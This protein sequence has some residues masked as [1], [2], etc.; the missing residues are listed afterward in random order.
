MSSEEA[1]KLGA[2]IGRLTHP[3]P[4][5]DTSSRVSAKRSSDKPVGQF[6]AGFAAAHKPIPQRVL[7]EE[8]VAKLSS[9]QQRLI[10]GQLGYAAPGQR[11]RRAMLP[12][13][14]NSFQINR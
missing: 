11:Q 4:A 9:Q 3:A 12:K 5:E 8:A 1:S 14:T 6:L 7:M 10:K 13:H 2:S